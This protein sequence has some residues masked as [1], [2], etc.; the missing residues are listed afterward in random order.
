M[1]LLHFVVPWENFG[2]NLGFIETFYG[3]C[4]NSQ[5]SSIVAQEKTFFKSSS[6][7]V[8]FRLNTFESLTLFKPRKK[9]RNLGFHLLMNHRLHHCQTNKENFKQFAMLWCATYPKIF[10][11]SSVSFIIH[12]YR[13]NISQYFLMIFLVP[14]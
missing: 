12:R 5:S 8:F 7:L 13:V 2:V 4:E 9:E 11:C 1:I 6:E 3:L 14:A 10:P